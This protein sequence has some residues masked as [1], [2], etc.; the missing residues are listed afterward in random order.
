MDV[1]SEVLQVVRLTGSIFFTANLS[2]PW[3]VLSPPH[4]ELAH[5]MQTK[6]GCVALFHI[7]TEGRCWI[8]VK[9]RE[10]FALEK[11][12]VIIFPHSCAHVMCSKLQ[13]SPVPILKLLHFEDIRGLP[14]INLG[15]GGEKIS[16]ICGY[17]KCDQQF[18]PLIGA[19]PEVLVLSPENESLS[20]NVTNAPALGSTV[21]PIIPGSW[22]DTT[23]TYLKQEMIH[24]NVGSNIMITRLTELLFVEVLRRYMHELPEKSNG[25]LAGIRD[26][27]IGKVLQLLHAYPEKKWDVKQLALA[28]GVSR[29]AL[30]QRF[31]ELIGEPPIRYLTGWRMQLAKHLLN[32]PHLSLSMVAEKVGYDSDIAFNRAF[33]RYTGHPPASWRNHALTHL[34]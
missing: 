31:N 11:G 18:N 3:S 33:K 23:I 24:K 14:E 5:H 25:W 6:V 16:F 32:Q 10:P 8:K 13:L 19:L 17:L 2:D 29:S 7:L 20:L 21:L 28:V 26:P 9:N 27:E 22:M 34:L 1:L 4:D 15:G 12:S 30:A